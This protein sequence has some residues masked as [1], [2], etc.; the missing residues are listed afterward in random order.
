MVGCSASRSTIISGNS[1][2]TDAKVCRNYL[3]DKDMLAKNYIPENVEESKYIFALNREV[4]YRSLNEHKCGL[5]AEQD[6]KDITKGVAAVV[7]VGLAVLAAA[8]GGGSGGV[9]NN[10][11]Y[12]WDQFYDGNYNLVWRC[13]S[14]ATGQFAYNSSCYGKAKYDNTWTGK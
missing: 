12:A 9:K 5:L 8:A 6:R 3:N 7:V 1:E 4:K 11:G 14:K 13:R 10:S 2:L